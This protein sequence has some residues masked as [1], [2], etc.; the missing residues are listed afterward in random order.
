MV[1]STLSRL[2]LDHYPILLDGGG[3]RRDP[4]PFGFENM[5]L[6]EG[7][8]DLL[9]G[10]WQGFNF[11][12]SCSFILVAKLKAVKSNLKTWNKEVFGK[13]E[14]NKSLALQ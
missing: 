13:V 10:W 14:V 9:K 1:Q 8:K 6:K 4:I 5:W 3:M 11:K 7:F 12:G 2:V